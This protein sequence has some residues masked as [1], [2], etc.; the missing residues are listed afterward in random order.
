MSKLKSKKRIKINQIAFI[1]R[2]YFENHLINYLE[3]IIVIS[4]L[5]I[6]KLGCYCDMFPVLIQCNE[7]INVKQ[8]IFQII[9]NTRGCKRKKKEEDFY[10]STLLKK[11]I[12][13]IS[14]SRVLEWK[15]YF[16]VC[17]LL[18]HKRK[19]ETIALAIRI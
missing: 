14:S 16:I 19:I 7:L 8:F 5:F 18:F 13:Y 2:C 15:I 1:F 6:L 12:K 9:T 4:H 17:E 11:E 3:E 10:L